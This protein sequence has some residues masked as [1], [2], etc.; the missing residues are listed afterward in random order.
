MFALFLLGF[1]ST[2]WGRAFGSNN[3]GD[4]LQRLQRSEHYKNGVFVNPIPTSLA[5]NYWTMTKRFLFEGGRRTPER[6]LSFPFLTPSTFGKSPATGLRLTW[7]GHST[8]LVEIDGQRVLTDPVLSKRASPSTLAGPERFFQAPLHLRDVPTLDAIVISHDHYDH[9]DHRT[10]LALDERTQR[11]F[12][13]LG[14]AA[15]LIGWGIDEKKI[16]ELDWWQGADHAGLHFVCTP[17]RHFS[18]RSLTD[19]NR[20]EWA[21]WSILGPSH[22]VFFSGDTGYFPGLADV[23]SRLG[24]FD[25]TLIESGAYDK[26]WA[27]IHLGPE[28]AIRAHRDL[29]GNVML[30]VHWGTFNLAL[31]D[32][33]EPILRLKKLAKEHGVLLAQPRPGQPFELEGHLPVEEWWRD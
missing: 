4:R 24:P 27:D 2:D 31:H 7:L 18:G 33:D 3:E 9:L 14:V 25:V 10:L 1:W 29:R 23:G 28:N 8:V 16:E 17:A 15:H 22:R 21:S 30:P 20:T 12:V 11:Y 19:T 5:F 6:A 13:P 32:W 26:L